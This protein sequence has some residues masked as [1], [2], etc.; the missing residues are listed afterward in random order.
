V[1]SITRYNRDTLVDGNEFR[2]LGESAVM[3][4]GLT[5]DR[6]NNLDGDFPAR[7]NVTNNFASE[8]GLYVKQTGFF[9]QGISMNST[10]RC[11]RVVFPCCSCA[12]VCLLFVFVCTALCVNLN[13][14]LPLLSSLVQHQS[15]SPLTAHYHLTLLSSCTTTLITH[16][17]LTLVTT[18]PT[19]CPSLSP[20]PTN[21]AI[22][23]R[24]HSPLQLPACPIT[25]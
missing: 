23:D 12:A 9:Y 5:G 15:L 16:Y 7:T 8:F 24:S 21:T 20:L 4:M 17:H 2:F 14:Y 25:C 6:Q 18:S 22:A 1:R 11:V 10:I 13:S 3:S 19:T